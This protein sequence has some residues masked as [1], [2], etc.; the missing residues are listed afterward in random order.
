MPQ[1]FC[2]AGAKSDVLGYKTRA[3]N[4][5]RLA[6][7]AA[8][9]L[10]SAAFATTSYAQSASD[11]DAA[12]EEWRANGLEWLVASS[13]GGATD[14]VTRQ[15]QPFMS[16]ILNMTARV[17]N[18]SGGSNTAAG[19][20]T[21]RDTECNTIVTWT[22][23]ALVLSTMVQKVDYDYSDFYPLGQIAADPSAIIVGLDTPYKTMQDLIDDA[24]A[25]PGEVTAAIGSPGSDMAHIINIEKAAGVKFNIVPLGGGTQARNAVIGGQA[26]MTEAGVYAS[27]NIAQQVRYL[28]V[29]ADSNPRPDLTQNAPTLTEALNGAK[30]E[31]QVS[32]Q[33]LFVSKACYE[34]HPDRFKELAD[35]LKAA[36]EDPE[37]KATVKKLNADGYYSYLSPEEFN[38]QIVDSIPGLQAFYDENMKGK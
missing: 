28:A 16:K 2:S 37:F 3:S 13:A 26:P 22:I 38:K 20:P 23:P 35:A 14:T 21:I 18:K 32:S 33:G 15:V 30:N 31:H 29:Q 25:R 4:N 19:A 27:Q 10:L 34:Q 6:V 5:R 17:Q 7:S 24:K 36:M 9:L 11:A 12:N 1:E 8:A